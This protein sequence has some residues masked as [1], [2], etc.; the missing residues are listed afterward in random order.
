MG[1]PETDS[2]ADTSL[3]PFIEAEDS[4]A[5]TTSAGQSGQRGGKLPIPGAQARSHLGRK[6][7]AEAGP[8]DRGLQ[9]NM[10]QQSQQLQEMFKAEQERQQSFE[11]LLRANQD[12]DERRFSAMQAQQQVQ[13]QMFSQVLSSIV[14]VLASGQPQYPPSQYPTSQHP[15]S[16]DTDR[17]AGFWPAQN[18]VLHPLH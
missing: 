9:A 15:P 7:E 8:S 4:D 6:R 2:N 10:D 5:S 18:S 13:M 14:N 1:D 17:D 11:N 3:T 16:Q 12:A